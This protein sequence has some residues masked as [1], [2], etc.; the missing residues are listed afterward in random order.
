MFLDPV[1]DM[2]LEGEKEGFLNSSLLDWVHPDE[3]ESMRGD[4]VRGNHGG[5]V[6]EGGVFGSVTT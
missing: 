4:L 1:L 3:V 5:G 2:H 6:E